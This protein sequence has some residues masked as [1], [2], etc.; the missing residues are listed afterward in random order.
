MM[1]TLQIVWFYLIGILLIGYTVL[2]G[3][4]LGVGIWHLFARKEEERQA[5][6][7]V[8]AP[9][10]DGNEVWL[11]TGGGAIFAAFPH[12]YATVFSGFYLAL[13]LALLGLILR[14]VS[15]EYRNKSD[16]AHW[17]A[18]WDV[19][20]AL[21]SI[22]PA[23]IFGVAVGNIMRGL[24]LDEAKNFAGNFFAML[25]PYSLLIGLLGFAMFATHGALY[26]RLKLRDT[27]SKR[28]RDWAQKAWL[29]Y[30]V[31]FIVSC[32][33]T[34]LTQPHLLSNYYLEPLLWFVP[35]FALI[36]LVL[37]GVFNH[38]S[39]GLPAFVASALSIIGL[40]GMV[41]FG[42]FPNLVPAIND[43]KMSLTINNAA[44]SELTLQVM[45]IIALIGMPIVL[46]Y[47]AWIYWVFRGNTNR[48][49]NKTDSQAT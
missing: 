19:A 38:I 15:V 44:S 7:D 48:E 37:I 49:K 5:H 47:T 43:P 45:F 35:S 11:L 17:R 21:G 27:H 39:S 42:L 24:P 22:L 2:D 30:L 40:W 10:W 33:T 16:S 26:L 25:N 41:G 34:V 3:F 1:T 32:V 12:V 13:M 6:L 46:A 20:F 9:V 36:M 28:A 18:A 8:I 14:A 4:D 23:L 31:L 29:A